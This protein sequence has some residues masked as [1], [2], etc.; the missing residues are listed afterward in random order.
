[1]KSYFASAFLARVKPTA[2]PPAK[3]FGAVK[4]ILLLVGIGL[5]EREQAI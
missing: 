1:M 2:A 5:V 4:V 3:M